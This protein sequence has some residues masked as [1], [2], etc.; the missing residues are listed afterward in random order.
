MSHIIAKWL[1]KDMK[2]SQPITASNIDE[3][4]ASGYLFG[5]LLEKMALQV[6][7][8]TSFQCASSVDAIVNNYASL[9]KTLREQLHIELSVPQAT[10]LLK[11]TPGCAA[12]LLHSIKSA[13]ANIPERKKNSAKSTS[14]I[15]F[16]SYP[17]S[18]LPA[19]SKARRN[20]FELS[21]GADAQV[22]PSQAF[23][24]RLR[25]KVGRVGIEAV[26][27]FIE[28]KIRNSNRI[29]SL[30]KKSEFALDIPKRYSSNYQAPVIS[31]IGR[32]KPLAAKQ[33][34]RVAEPTALPSASKEISDT[35][36]TIIMFEAKINTRPQFDDVLDASIT[37]RT[38]TDFY[39][40]RGQ[41]DPKQHLDMLASMIPSDKESTD[42]S[43]LYVQKIRVCFVDPVI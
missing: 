25:A 3:K 8:Q 43:K 40:T 10:S 39:K 12:R 20:P 11:A 14:K 38:I 41:L 17:S 13:L 37:P 5:E 15:G 18:P 4:F 23:K 21:V 7:F 34:V 1:E 33:S 9:E 6:D 22:S 35:N 16:E 29:P 42:K 32:I 26:T 27:N 28:P 24:E 36:K 2:I 31:K 19:R 30:P